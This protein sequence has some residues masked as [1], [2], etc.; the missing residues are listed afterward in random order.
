MFPYQLSTLQFDATNEDE[1]YFTAEVTFKYL[2]YNIVD[3]L[4]NP[5][6]PTK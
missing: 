3:R 5:L 4:G 1:E 6:N 2:M